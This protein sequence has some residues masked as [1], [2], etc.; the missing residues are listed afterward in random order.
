MVVS[1]DGASIGIG[2]GYRLAIEVWKFHS[3]PERGNVSQRT[4]AP[5][6]NWRRAFRR[7]CKLAGVKGGHPHRFR[8]TFATE[9]LL[10]GVPIERVLDTARSFERQGYGTALCPLGKGA[11]GVIRGGFGTGVGA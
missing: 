5:A 4:S 3:L 7:L 6:Q 9:L 11:A 2:K 8:D 10:A 1:T